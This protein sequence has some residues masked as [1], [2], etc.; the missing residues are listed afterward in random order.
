[1]LLLM[2]G[3][4]C[5]IYMRTNL[6]MTMTCMVNSSAVLELENSLI[7]DFSELSPNLNRSR[8]V[9]S[10]CGRPKEANENSSDFNGE[11][12]LNDYGVSHF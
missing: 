11:A 6:G 7:E 8:I 12:V 5:T 10:R 2:T 1:M 4:F 3:Y 9:P